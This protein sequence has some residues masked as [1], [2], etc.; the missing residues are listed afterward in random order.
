ME[1]YLLYD[2]VHPLILE[3]S[4]INGRWRIESVPDEDIEIIESEYPY[5]DEVDS[6]WDTC[7]VVEDKVWHDRTFVSKYK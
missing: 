2:M 1:D 4:L 5:L 6:T 3:E 7:T